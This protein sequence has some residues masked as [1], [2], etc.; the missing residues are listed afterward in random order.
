M[1]QVFIPMGCGGWEGRD[2]P[3]LRPARAFLV[4]VAKNGSG[5]QSHFLMICSHLTSDSDD[6]PDITT[7]RAFL[8]STSQ[9]ISY[10]EGIWREYRTCASLPSF[11]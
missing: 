1:N 9:G 5:T 3:A 11:G 8:A 7:L 2:E 6:K 4:I 10:H